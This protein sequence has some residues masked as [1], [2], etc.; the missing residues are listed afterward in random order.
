[1]RVLIVQPSVPKY[2][3]DFFSR[4]SMQ[5]GLNIVVSGDKDKSVSSD[6]YT[7]LRW[8]Q[9]VRS[10]QLVKGVFF[11]NLDIDIGQF[12][13]VVIF[14]NPRFLSNLSLLLR[15]KLQK[16]KVVWWTQ[17]HSFSSSR[18]SSFLRLLIARAADAILFYTDF[19]LSEYRRRL[20][21]ASH[22]HALNNGIDTST[23]AQFRQRYNPNLRACNILFIGRLIEK[24]QL[25][26]L[27]EAIETLSNPNLK[28]HIIGDGDLRY[29]LEAMSELMGISNKIIWY[30]DLRAE[31]E[32]SRVA[33]ECAILAYPGAVGLALLHAMAY[34]LPSII[35][36]DLRYHGPEAI[37]LGA[38][39]NGSTFE[40]GS[41]QDLARAIDVSLA[42]PSL[43]EQQSKNALVTMAASYNTENMVERMI[44]LLMVFDDKGELNAS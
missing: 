5:P 44:Q 11:Q 7:K 34:G 12:D 4:L 35:H 42:A 8:F 18:L 15:C 25:S 10:R 33:N 2:R 39:E 6:E 20:P 28:L 9:Q 23:I 22:L 43:R 36:S 27:F 21:R 1:M 16:V 26:L 13:V 29:D 38:P 3:L 24:T 30:G 37:C 31:E 40:R 32:I 41:A 17:L 19:E 14:G